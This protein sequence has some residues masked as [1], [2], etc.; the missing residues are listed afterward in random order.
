[1]ADFSDVANFAVEH[2]RKFHVVILFFSLVMVPGLMQTLTPIDV[3]SYDMD[4]PEMVAETVIDDEFSSKEL[5]VG[6]VVSIRDPSYIQNGNQ[7]PH[8]DADGNPDRLIL[9]TP[10]EIAPFQGS[11][12]GF[13]GEGIPEGGVF[14]L[15]FLRELEQKIMIA[16]SNPLAEYYRPIV[17][18][19]TGESANGTLSLFEQ[20]EAFMDNRS[21]F[22]REATDP[23]G[24]IVQPLTNWSDCGV[25]ECLRFGDPNLTQAHIDLAANRMIIANPS[26]FLRWTTTDRAF[27]PDSTSPVIGPVGGQVGEDGTFENA[28][29]MPGR[30]SASSTWILIQLDKVAMADTGFTFV[31][32]EARS[33]P[34]SLTWHGLELY[35]TPPELT[36]EECQE[37]RESGEGPCSAD[38]AL[39]SLEH[40][41]RS[42]DQQ[43]V[44]L[45]AP[46]VGINIEVNRELQ[47]SF[48][49][50]AAMFACILILLWGSLR[51]VSDV[52]I[53][54]TTLG[55]SLLWMQGMIG[56]RK[57]SLR[58]LW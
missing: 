57:D 53:V 11:D 37:S 44:T 54:A 41:I 23:F 56:Y 18:E 55:F 8:T 25:L 50:L 19:L 15:T 5:T 35:T 4:S 30:W 28:T 26:V 31:W 16:R 27:L 45:L 38:W 47:Q 36:A 51:R 9:P 22:T 20:F 58:K 13:S 34:G 46:P 24:N 49:L 17:S 10:Q 12:E 7:A 2:R 32:N 29:W 39:L 52:A 48:T 14:N 43:S 33:E 42:T 3:E 1:M 6:F 21:L 40:E